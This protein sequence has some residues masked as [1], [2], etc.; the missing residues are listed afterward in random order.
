MVVAPE[1]RVAVDHGVGL[2]DRARADLDLGSDD[3]VGPDAHTRADPCLRGHA[4]GGIDAGWIERRHL[5]EELRLRH[6]VLPRPHLS[7]HAA[8][9]A[10]PVQDGDLEPELV[11]GNGGTAELRV[12]DAYEVDLEASGIGRVLE[13]PDSRGLGQAFHQ[14]DPRHHGGPGE[15]A[16]EEF[17]GAGDVLDRDQAAGG[18]VLEHA[19]HEDEGVLGGNL[20]DEARNVDGGRVHGTS[21]SSGG[22]VV[23]GNAQIRQWAPKRARERHEEPTSAQSCERTAW[24]GS[25]SVSSALRSGAERRGVSGGEFI[26]TARWAM[27]SPPEIKA[28]AAIRQPRTANRQ[29]PATPWG[30]APA[31]GPPARGPRAW[32]PVPPARPRRPSSPPRPPSR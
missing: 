30:S 3:R 2:D 28:W 27:N 7:A 20:P 5:E 31:S 17:L 11:A 25:R 16:F 32:P 18:V 9:R 8:E 19:V 15:V 21:H 13:E 26:A 1:G 12:V 14:Q 29:Q 22:R 10:P 24:S 23:A 4:R 6:P